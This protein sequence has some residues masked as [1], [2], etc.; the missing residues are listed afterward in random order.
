[1]I[2][3]FEYCDGVM[4]RTY[5]KTTSL[6]SLSYEVLS[7]MDYDQRTTQINKG[8]GLGLERE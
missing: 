8:R 1:M 4:K 7:G 5:L 3:P 6:V 2:D